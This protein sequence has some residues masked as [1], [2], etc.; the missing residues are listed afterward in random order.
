MNNNKDFGS[1]NSESAL[2][3]F[4]KGIYNAIHCKA[5]LS[6]L[7]VDFVKAFYLVRLHLSREAAGVGGIGFESFLKRRV[8]QSRIAD[9]LVLVS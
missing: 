5:K 3:D 1:G 6:E 7:F 2:I 8:L 4:M 9:H